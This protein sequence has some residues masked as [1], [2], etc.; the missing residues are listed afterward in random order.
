MDILY[1][2]N[3]TASGGG[4]NGRSATDDKNVDVTLVSPKEMGGKGDTPGT[5]PE[6][7]FAVGYAGCYLGAVRA[8][9]AKEKKTVSPDASVTSHVGV[10]RRDDGAGLGLRITL[11]VHLPGLSREEAEEIAQKA[12]VICPYSYSIKGNVEVT[13]NIV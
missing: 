9:A 12:H 6:Q 13:T 11:D 5:N 7:L 10:G 2:A 4:R 3:A 1:T 8:A